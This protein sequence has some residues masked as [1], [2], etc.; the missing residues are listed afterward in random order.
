MI[1]NFN[2]INALKILVFWFFM[3]QLFYFYILMKLNFALFKKK[4]IS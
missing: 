1:E 3:F 4:S 2:A